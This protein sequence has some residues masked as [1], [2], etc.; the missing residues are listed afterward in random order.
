MNRT[1]VVIIMGLLAAGC[2]ST[3]MKKFIGLDARY[4]EVESGPPVNVLDLPDG[5]R[6]FQY[7]WGG[8]T[9]VVPAT[10]RTEGKGRLVGDAAYY[11][12][13]RVQT[14]GFV[15]DNPGCLITY[16]STWDAAKKGW[17]VTSISYPKRLVC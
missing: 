8:G 5:H 11:S 10:T 16:Y 2:V 4:I 6:A 17:I 12:E 14:G 3:H 13:E 15:V 7:L 1:G 9:Y